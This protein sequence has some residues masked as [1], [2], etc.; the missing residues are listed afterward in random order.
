MNR[1]AALYTRCDRRVAEG[2]NL[3]VA[4]VV[5]PGLR[6]EKD[7]SHLTSF[8]AQLIKLSL[9]LRVLFLFRDLSLLSLFIY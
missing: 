1:A 5:G 4:S 3:D 9:S 7:G 2:W 8:I 6:R